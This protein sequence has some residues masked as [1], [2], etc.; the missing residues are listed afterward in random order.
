MKDERRHERSRSRNREAGSAGAA[1]VRFPEAV[2][3]TDDYLTCF[4]DTR[5]A[6]SGAL[7]SVP[8][9]IGKTVG[10]CWRIRFRTAAAAAKPREQVASAL[11]QRTASRASGCDR[12][13]SIEFTNSIRSFSGHFLLQPQGCVSHTQISQTLRQ[14]PGKRTQCVSGTRGVDMLV[15]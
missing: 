10:Y 9:S 7:K 12:S 4:P 6:F 3:P 11:R 15:T 8:P 13:G 14:A 1:T 5:R 2:F